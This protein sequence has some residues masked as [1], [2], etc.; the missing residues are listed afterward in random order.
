MKPI[1]VGAVTKRYGGTAALDGID[2]H[3]EAGEVYGLLGRNG[4]GKTTLMRVL[5]GLVRP[6]S[7]TVRVLG[8]APGDPAVF[9]RVGALIEGAAF[10]PHLSGRDNLRLLTRYAGLDESEVD[11]ALAR[12]GLSGRADDRYRG[13]SLGMKQR[14]GVASALLGSP[15]LVVL[16]E[17]ANGL[18]PAGMAAL[19]E[20]IRSIRDEG[21]TVLLS[22]H[23]LGEV[24]QVCDRVG[25]LHGGR[26]VFEGTLAGLTGSLEERFFELTG[27]GDWAWT[28]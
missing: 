9:R 28:A 2:L 1:E 21:G 17:P 4:A 20:L 10:Y 27:D 5:L 6:A 19:R 11:K 24:E 22:S 14:L 3:V 7:G 25:V 12:V 16:D 26:L 23:L 18:D 15:E 8:H 13:Y